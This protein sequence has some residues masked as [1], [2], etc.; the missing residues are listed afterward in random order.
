MKPILDF[1]KSL[2]FQQTLIGVAGALVLLS[3]L[4]RRQCLVR[5]KFEAPLRTIDRYHPTYLLDVQRRC[6]PGEKDKGRYCIKKGC[7]SGMERGTGSGSELCYPECLDGYDNNGMSRC[8]KKCPAG[9]EQHETTCTNSGHSFKKDAIPCKGCLGP[10]PDREA[11]TLIAS[12]PLE[13]IPPNAPVIMTPTTA[14]YP[15]HVVAHGVG[16]VPVWGAG[17][18]WG[19]EFGTDGDHSHLVRA[20]HDHDTGHRAVVNAKHAHGGV[21]HQHPTGG[22][23]DVWGQLKKAEHFE[24][25]ESS[26][27]ATFANGPSSVPAPAAGPSQPI[28]ASHPETGDPVTTKVTINLNEPRIGDPDRPCP[29]GYVLSGDMCHENCPPHYKDLGME[30][31][32]DGYTLNRTSYDRGDGVPYMTKYP[33]YDLIAAD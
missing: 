8:Y 1:F 10:P 16:V 9:F 19:D 28:Q 17:G 14:A 7:P 11:D 18:S 25:G 2:T 24:G 27:P 5:E 30:C 4:S 33:K 29:R 32:R 23:A 26:D 13:A 31:L 3:L 22:G 20:I 6:L 21:G 15:S 12:L